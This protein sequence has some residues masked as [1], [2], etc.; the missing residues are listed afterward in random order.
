MSGGLP[1]LRCES[2][3]RTSFCGTRHGDAE[4]LAAARR[5]RILD[6]CQRAGLLVVEDNPGDL[7]LLLTD[8]ISEAENNRDEQFGLNRL[9]QRMIEHAAYPLPGI[10]ARIQEEVAG[11]GAQTDYQTILLIRVRH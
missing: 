7:F 8:G 2:A 9:E 6:I 3:G 10:Y 11:H 4:T 5:P 1:A